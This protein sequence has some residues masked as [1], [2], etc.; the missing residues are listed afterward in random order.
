LWNFYNTRIKNSA[1][2]LNEFKWY[3]RDARFISKLRLIKFWLMF[4]G[5]P[6]YF[7]ANAGKLIQIMPRP[8]PSTSFSI[9]PL[10]SSNNSMVYILSY[11]QNHKMNYKSVNRQECHVR[12]RNCTTKLRRL[13]G[14]RRH[15]KWFKSNPSIAK[16]KI[17]RLEKLWSYHCPILLQI[18]KILSRIRG[19]VT[20]N[21][22]F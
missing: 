11:V 20:N 1:N 5:F 22:G 4:Y 2:W 16:N 9:P 15:K 12:S 17:S 10:P 13:A 7:Q 19:C 8:V 18:K 6:R 3:S 14:R 21:C